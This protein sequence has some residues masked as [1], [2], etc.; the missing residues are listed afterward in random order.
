MPY[1]DGLTDVDKLFDAFEKEVPEK[2]LFQALHLA[3][4]AMPA[5]WW[6]THKENFDG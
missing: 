1:Y 6:G 3:L 2:H 5:I 4:R